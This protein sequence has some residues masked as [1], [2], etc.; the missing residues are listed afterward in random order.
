MLISIRKTPTGTEW[1]QGYNEGYL[2]FEGEIKT[3]GN[4]NKYWMGWT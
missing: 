2:Q 1:S 3:Y 4:W